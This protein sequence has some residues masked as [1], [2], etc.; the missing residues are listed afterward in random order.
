MPS[1]Y[2]NKPATSYKKPGSSYRRPAARPYEQV[3]TYYRAPASAPVYRKPA[4]KKKSAFSG[5]VPY[6]METGQTMLVPKSEMQFCNKVAS[7]HIDEH[8]KEHR[9]GL[10]LP[11]PQWKQAHSAVVQNL[12]AQGI[13]SEHIQEKKKNQLQNVAHIINKHRGNID[14]LLGGIEHVAD[15]MG[16]VVG[17]LTALAA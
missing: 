14:N 11:L 4:Y 2:Y 12:L 3:K 13:Y 9:H 7:F 17:A 5:H 15:S 16:S 10:R 6:K 8:I 1:K